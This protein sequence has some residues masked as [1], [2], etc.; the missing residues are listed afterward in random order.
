MDHVD[1]AICQRLIIINFPAWFCTKN[2]LKNKKDYGEKIKEL[3]EKE[4]I[5]G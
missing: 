5:H 4:E 2:D 3:R 1:Y